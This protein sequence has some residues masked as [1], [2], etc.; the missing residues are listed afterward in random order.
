MVYQVRHNGFH[1]IV[2]MKTEN[3]FGFLDTHLVVPQVSDMPS[4]V[5]FLE[6]SRVLLGEDK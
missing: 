2:R 4:F 6:T 1:R 3:I 5:D